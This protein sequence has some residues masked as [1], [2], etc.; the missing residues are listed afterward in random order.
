MRERQF[1]QNGEDEPMTD[2]ITPNSYSQQ[3]AEVLRL[4]DRYR[5]CFLDQK[6]YARRLSIYQRWDTGTNLFAG[7]AMI[8]SLATRNSDAWLSVVCYA[9]GVLAALMFIGKPI[10]KVSEQIE[11]YTA[12]HCAFSEVFEEIEG[13]VADIRRAGS[14]TVDHRARADK[15]FDRCTSLSIREDVSVNQKQLQ[16]FKEEVE[17]AI[18]PET[19]WLPTE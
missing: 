12:L 19:L 1:G 17:R 14:L 7:I 8:L 4:H 3:Q 2:T 18:P 10:F 6:Y 5:R 15:I 11:R 13:L 16:Q 9:T